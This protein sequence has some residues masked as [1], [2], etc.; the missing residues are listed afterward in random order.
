MVVSK[1]H[2]ETKKYIVFVFVFSDIRHIG[3]WKHEKIPIQTIFEHKA[4]VIFF[5][6]A[7]N[8][9]DVDVTLVVITVW[10]TKSLKLNSNTQ[11]VFQRFEI[12]VWF[13]VTIIKSKFLSNQQNFRP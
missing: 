1:I 5:L 2:E 4:T 7:Y 11:K 10:F 3:F 6:V 13:L 12:K 9:P 8:T